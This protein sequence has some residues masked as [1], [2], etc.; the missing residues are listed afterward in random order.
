[1]AL[2]DAL[3]D[4]PL[5]IDAYT[6]E[7]RSRHIVA[8][9]FEMDRLTTTIHLKGA[10][11]EGLGED[12]TYT[13]ELQKAQQETGPVLPLAG[14]WTLD[15]L[16]RHLDGLDLFHGVDPEMPAFRNYRRWAFESA[17]A[18]LALRQAGRSLADVLGREPGPI[19]FVVSLRL[20]EPPSLE[21]VT[22]RL[23]AYPGTRFK[24]DSSPSW[25]DGFLSDLAATGAVASV[26]FK[27]AYKNTPVDVPTD[28]HLYRRVA[29]TFPDAWLEDPDLTVPEADE[30]LRPFRDRITWDAPIH[31][32]A[33]IEAL[34]FL[35]RTINVKPSRI[36]TWKE[37]LR[38]YEWCAER[39]IVSYGGGQSELGVGR[40]QIQYLASI[41]HPGE[42]NDIA[43][44]GYD[45]ADFP[46]TG[47]PP[48]PLPPEIEP[49]GFR[50]RS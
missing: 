7:G 36:G 26:D 21:P 43:P 9:E 2:Y 1:M 18:D 45:W 38:T 27:G 5:Q 6:L 39:G 19:A 12:V 8:G 30:A 29:E 33:D 23:E 13:G 20:G 35:P 46:A 15:S 49:T 42:P 11:E 47:L 4:L 41:F 34:P 16:S 40:G 24:L 48:S 22:R 3:A 10:G 50:R 32:V 37:L 28:P 31:G 25:D 14:S 17:A 44:S